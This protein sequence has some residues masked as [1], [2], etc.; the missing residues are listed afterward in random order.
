[1]PMMKDIKLPLVQCVNFVLI[2][3]MKIALHVEN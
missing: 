1:L 2:P 3:L